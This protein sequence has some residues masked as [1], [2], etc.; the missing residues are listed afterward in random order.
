[1][2]FAPVPAGGSGC[3]RRLWKGKGLCPSCGK[4]FLGMFLQLGFGLHGGFRGVLRRARKLLSSFHQVL[5]SANF[6]GF[7]FK[8]QPRATVVVK[9]KDCRWLL[10]QHSLIKVVRVTLD[11]LCI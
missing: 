8:L 3:G 11:S 6:P 5:P 4:C 7:V 2:L 10:N 1:M 9:S